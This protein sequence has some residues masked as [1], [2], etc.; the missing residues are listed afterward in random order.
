MTSVTSFC[1]QELQHQHQRQAAAAAVNQ[2]Q[3][4]L[5]VFC[6]VFLI[7]RASYLYDD[8]IIVNNK[9]ITAVVV[10]LFS[11]FAPSHPIPTSLSGPARAL[12]TMIQCRI[13]L[14]HG[15]R[16]L[17]H[18]VRFIFPPHFLIWIISFTLLALPLLVFFFKSRLRSGVTCVYI[19]NINTKA[20]FLLLLHHQFLIY[21]IRTGY[22]VN[23]L[24]S[25]FGGTRNRS[26]PACTFCRETEKDAGS[27]T[28][29]FFVDSCRMIRAVGLVLNRCSY[30]SLNSY[31]GTFDS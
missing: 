12:E 20:L 10:A 2:R 1:T 18:F 7:V 26:C 31:D 29:F 28:F 19:N 3:D 25:V 11:S 15:R 17:I 23:Y 6:S 30:S 14:V 13:F 9:S 5:A 27:S 21:L 8:T 22:R 4:A 24:F 16:P